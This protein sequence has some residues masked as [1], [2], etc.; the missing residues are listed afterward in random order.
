[1]RLRSAVVK[2]WDAHIYCEEYHALVDTLE[3]E[4]DY[5]DASISACVLDDLDIAYHSGLT[6]EEALSF[7]MGQW[8]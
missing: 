5:S 8:E 6:P 7:I 3:D 1:M 4:D 2:L